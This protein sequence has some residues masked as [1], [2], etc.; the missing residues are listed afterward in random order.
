MNILSSAVYAVSDTIILCVQILFLSVAAEKH[1]SK[2]RFVTVALAAAIMG[3]I[4]ELLFYGF[5]EGSTFMLLIFNFPRLCLLTLIALK[6][7]CLKDIIILMII[8]FMCAILSSAV[9]VLFPTAL[10]H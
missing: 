3:F 10:P 1:C 9:T 7:L 2:I 5:G 6:L 8:Q 4:F